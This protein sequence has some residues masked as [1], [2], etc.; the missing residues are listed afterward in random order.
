MARRCVAGF[1]IG[2]RSR[3]DEIPW[4][5]QHLSDQRSLRRCFAK[6][7]IGTQARRTNPAPQTAGALGRYE[8]PRFPELFKC[9]RN[10]GGLRR[11]QMS[12][13]KIRDPPNLGL[14]FELN[15]DLGK[16]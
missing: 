9:G 11:C 8:R 14:A 1:I 16:W 15:G 2:K 12:Y 10:F 3:G 7:K 4:V 13:L 6:V 5:S